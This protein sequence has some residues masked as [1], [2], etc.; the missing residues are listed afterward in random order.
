MPASPS[1]AVATELAFDGA[2][3]LTL[4]LLIGLRRQLGTLLAAGD[5]AHVGLRLLGLVRGSLSDGWIG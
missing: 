3:L 2:Y 4:W 1:F 5:S